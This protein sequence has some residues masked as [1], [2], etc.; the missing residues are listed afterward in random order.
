MVSTILFLAG[1]FFLAPS[2]AHAFSRVVDTGALAGAKPN[3]WAYGVNSSGVVV[4]VCDSKFGVQHAFVF[5]PA[6]G[7]FQDISPA[8]LDSVM[9]YSEANAVSDNG[10]VV[11]DRISEDDMYDN[12]FIWTRTGG[13]K[14][15]G[16]FGKPCQWNVATAVN[17]AG[18][19]A[20]YGLAANG[21]TDA[22]VWSAASGMLDISASGP[23]TSAWPVGINSSGCVCGNG[24]GNTVSNSAFFWSPSTG[25]ID[26]GDPAG[27]YFG[28]PT[29]ISDSGYVVGYSFDG[30]GDEHA[31]IWS[32][33]SGFKLLPGPA[34]STWEEADAIRGQTIVCQAD[35]GVYTLNITK[36]KPV[37]VTAG[38]SDSSWIRSIAGI[39]SAGKVAGSAQF[40]PDTAPYTHAFLGTED[41]GSIAMT[42][43]STALAINSSGQV[44]GWSLTGGA[45][46]ATVY[47][48]D[49]AEAIT[50]IGV[51]G[52]AWNEQSAGYAINDSGLVAGVSYY[53]PSDAFLWSATSGM[54]NLGSL[55]SSL[56]NTIAEGITDS[57]EVVGCAENQAGIQDGFIGTTSGL[58]DLGAPTGFNGSQ[59]ICVNPSG[60]IAGGAGIGIDGFAEAAVWTP[61]GGWNLLGLLPG[62]LDSYVNGVNNSGLAV[63]NASVSTGVE[64][65]VA[66]K[67]LGAITDLG[68][69]PGGTY[70]YAAGVNSSGWIVGYADNAKHKTH[71]VVWKPGK[72]IEDLNSLVPTDGMTLLWATSINDS[73]EIAAVALLPDGD[74]HGVVIEP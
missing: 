47:N 67:K 58:I 49:A 18:Q 30:S 70:S 36:L 42:S 73:D 12:A 45:A 37:L 25:M 24:W 41:L 53:N 1:V 32:Q 61:T 23:F 11:G 72:K 39:D 35:A 43:S 54:L 63:G 34:G 15:I 60:S 46:H 69:L 20:G 9:D 51:L 4:G 55:S 57:G 28:Q 74:V 5:D 3:S 50:D 40:A 52:A 31:W 29:G 21:D 56:S 66:W 48:P 68:L 2:P 8:G 59:I 38:P 26:I 7:G 6:H 13:F 17:D 16:T 19:V 33:T 44:A 71:A 10:V 22:F 64:H 65:G 27:N 14:Y 62:G